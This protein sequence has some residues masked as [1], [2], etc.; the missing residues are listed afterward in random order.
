MKLCNLT[1]QGA[2]VVNEP[3]QHS[4]LLRFYRLVLFTQERRR[5]IDD[6]KT[7]AGCTV[8]ASQVGVR[9]LRARGGDAADA[10]GGRASAAARRAFADT[11]TSR[12]GALSLCGGGDCRG[13]AGDAAAVSSR[14]GRRRA[15]VRGARGTGVEA[16]GGRGGSA[17]CRAPLLWGRLWFSGGS[18]AVRWRRAGGSA[19]CWSDLRFSTRVDNLKRRECFSKQFARFRS[20][21]GPCWHSPARP[22]L[23]AECPS[24]WAPA[25]LSTRQSGKQRYVRT[26]NL[27]LRCST[28]CSYLHAL[29][30]KT[31][32][33]TPQTRGPAHYAQ[34]RPSPLF[35]TSALQVMRQTRNVAE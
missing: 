16:G 15:R 20:L 31:L 5:E 17:A 34:K 14:R 25:T 28:L 33:G 1:W 9:P 26:H 18:A 4:L 22:V 13:G 35:W 29:P 6:E 32:R 24:Q 3:C 12:L 30:L 7:G 10:R 2:D 23:I 21:L 11:Q 27:T 8:C 19:H